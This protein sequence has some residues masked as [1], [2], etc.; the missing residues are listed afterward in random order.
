MAGPSANC[1]LSTRFAVATEA[2]EPAIRRMLRDNPMRGAID[3]SFEREPDYFRGAALAGG[4]DKTIVAFAEGELVCMGRCTRRECWVNGAV[5]RAGYLAELRLDSRARGRVALLHSGYRFF[6]EL[7]RHHSAELYFTSIADDNQPAR[8]LLEAGVR[9]LPSYGFLAEFD[10]LLIAVPRRPRATMLR[11]EAAGPERIH[12]LLR[13]LNTPSHQ[14]AAVWT[15]ERLRALEDH[16]M[17]LDRFLLALDGSQVVA[18][19]A[20][21]D[22]RAFRQ[23]VIRGYSTALAIARPLLNIGSQIF[24]AP[25]LPDTGSVLAHAFLSPLAFA[26]GAEGLLADLIEASFPLAA[27]IRAEFLTVGLPTTDPRLPVL[28]RRFS[29]RTWRSRLYRV[30]WPDHEPVQFRENGAAFLPEVALL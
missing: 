2:D 5:R 24:G 22:Q 30:D 11:V 13:V 27:Q 8:R 6:H 28:R 20:L 18:C 15:A 26:R 17:P 19:G 12:D 7:Q 21:W 9:G 29:T 3:V 25:R 16:G 10:T 23:T 14:L 1:E 4:D